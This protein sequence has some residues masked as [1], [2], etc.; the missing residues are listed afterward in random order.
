M[1][2]L[3]R[4]VPNFLKPVLRK[5]YSDVAD[6]PP[7]R[8]LRY[9]KNKRTRE[10]IH[11]FWKNPW[12]GANRPEDYLEGEGQSKL[13]VHLVREYCDTS[14]SFLE[15]GCNVGRN[16]NHLFL[17]GFTQLWGIEINNEAVELLKHSFPEMATH[18]TVTN[19]SAEEALP[20][21]ADKSIDVVYTVAV[22]EHIHPES[23]SL[24]AEMVRLAKD[25][26]ITI[27]DEK[28]LSWRHFP[29]DY[30]KVFEPLGFSQVFELNC[31]NVD[32]LDSNFIARVFKRDHIHAID[33]NAG[34]LK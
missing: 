25:T 9:I 2:E 16:L 28:M 23:E 20:G 27:E 4:L 10:E 26:I 19:T 14:Q 34:V 18:L 29:R 21:F 3:A 13:L 5:A 33:S 7:F 1:Y 22:L 30:R 32:G 15:I 11:A 24:F 8:K 12:Q 31:V 6:L 17:A